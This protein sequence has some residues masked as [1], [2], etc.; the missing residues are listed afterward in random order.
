MAVKKYGG[1]CTDT[2]KEPSEGR[3]NSVSVGVAAVCAGGISEKVVA[4]RICGS[5][6]LERRY[7]HIHAYGIPIEAD[8]RY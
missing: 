2:A 8:Q 3:E 7:V 6:C 4:I 5:F 1:I